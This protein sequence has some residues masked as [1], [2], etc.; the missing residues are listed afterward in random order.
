[1]PIVLGIGLVLHPR[2][3]SNEA[4]QLDIVARHASAWEAA[5]VFIYLAAAL[6][7]G[8]T[9]ALVRLADR[10]QAKG[11]LAA[12]VVA[13]FGAVA[14]AATAAIELV[15][16]HVVQSGLGQT[17]AAA[18]FHQYETATD[19]GLAVFIAA[20]A[21]SLGFAALAVVLWRSRALPGG[22]ALCLALGAVAAPLP[23]IAVR[24]LGAVLLLIGMAAAAHVTLRPR[25]SVRTPAT[26]EAT[27]IVRD[28][29]AET[30]N[31]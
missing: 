10:H 30:L 25:D 12:G 5:H 13:A 21:L 4:R 6:A 29:T 3:T 23:V 1:M 24:D 8:A 11:A 18:V 22:A 15:T 9:A 20:F 31:S 2:E 17:N 14:L 27:G 26:S 28:Y 16:R 7:I 19:L